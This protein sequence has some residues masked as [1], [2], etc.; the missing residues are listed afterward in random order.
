VTSVQGSEHF[1]N[2]FWQP[3]VTQTLLYG[4]QLLPDDGDGEDCVHSRRSEGHRP[5]FILRR[6]NRFCGGTGVS[7]LFSVT[8]RR[9]AAE[10]W[11]WI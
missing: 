5:D 9:L 1:A 2:G 4:N 3:P 7:E 8:I 10:M 6:P 11:A